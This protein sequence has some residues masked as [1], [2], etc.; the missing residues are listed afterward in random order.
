MLVIIRVRR[1]GVG[2]QRILLQHF[3]S[4]LDSSFELRVVPLPDE[5]GIHFNFHVR[6][7][8]VTLHFPL[9]LEAVNRPAWG[10][11]VPA[12]DQRRIATDPDQSSPGADA[13]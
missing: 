1:P 3:E 5:L 7:D 6:R 11:D 9:T 13:D 12:V 8:T 4:D 2:G 10:G